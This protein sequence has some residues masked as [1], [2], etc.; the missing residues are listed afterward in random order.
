MLCITVRDAIG[1]QSDGSFE[2]LG[3]RT[4]SVFRRAFCRRFARIPLRAVFFCAFFES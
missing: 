4:H 1:L 3:A 2:G